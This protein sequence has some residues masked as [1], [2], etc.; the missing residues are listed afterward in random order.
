MIHNHQQKTRFRSLTDD[1]CCIGMNEIIKV[2]FNL[3]FNI[4]NIHVRVLH[5]AR[6]TLGKQLS[7]ISIA[8]V[9]TICEC[10]AAP[11][12]E[13]FTVIFT[14][15]FRV[16]IPRQVCPALIIFNISMIPT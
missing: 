5:N 1:L 6:N 3:V 15:C 4:D 12:T 2:L 11:F 7:N 13:S 9:L 10:F 16:E 14:W 8:F